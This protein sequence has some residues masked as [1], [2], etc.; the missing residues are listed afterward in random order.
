MHCVEADGVEV[1][2]LA[3]CGPVIRMIRSEERC[4]HR[5]GGQTVG[6]VLVVLP[7]LVQHHVALVREL[8]LGQR[9]Q[10]VA[11]A[12]RLHPQPKLERTGRQHFPVVGPV[13]VGRSVERGAG[14]LQR[15]EVA[16]VVM[17]GPFEHQ[18]LEEVRKAGVAGPFVLRSH[19]VPHVDRDNRAVVVLV[20]D[21]VEAVLERVL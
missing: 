8:G 14:T 6:P 7:A 2:D 4:H 17:R 21:H 3:D 1:G 11:H 15:L 19:V 12:V 10:Q 16:M 9:R 18:V 20:Q 13:G 5:H